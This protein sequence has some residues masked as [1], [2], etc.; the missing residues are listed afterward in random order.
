MSKNLRD[1]S[2]HHANLPFALRLFVEL[3]LDH[4]SRCRAS[5]IVDFG[6]DTSNSAAA[7]SVSHLKGG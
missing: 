1:D 6:T 7:S 2:N 5:L 3:F 4:F